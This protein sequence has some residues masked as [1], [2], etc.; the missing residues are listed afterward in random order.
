MQNGTF[1]AK[2]G[3]IYESRAK[4]EWDVVISHRWAAVNWKSRSRWHGSKAPLWLFPQ[5]LDIEKYDHAWCLGTCKST[6]RLF[7]PSFGMESGYGGDDRA[8]SGLSVTVHFA[9]YLHTVYARAYW[10]NDDVR[11]A[12]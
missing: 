12:R 9:N 8:R 1:D 4:G 3:S 11:A 10:L 2:G 7:P 6:I 5:D